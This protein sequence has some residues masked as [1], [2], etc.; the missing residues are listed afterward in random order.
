M[1]KARAHPLTR[2][3]FV[4]GAAG[5]GIAGV[6]PRV[7]ASASPREHKLVAAAARA[8]I[9]S[10]GTLTDVWAYQGTVPGPE[11][12]VRQGER[13]RVLVENR[14]PQ[15]TTVHWHGVR[16][17]NAMDGVPHLTQD[18]I[19]PGK[20]FLYEFDCPDAG[21]FWYH[22]HARSF[23]QVERG[24]SGALI[25]E[26]RTPVAADRD[27]V[28]V[29]DDW[30]LTPEA[31]I[32]EDF[33][34]MMDATHAGRLGNT[35]TINGRV[36]ER[37]AVRAGERIRLRLINAANARIFGLEFGGHQPM[38]VALD[39]QPVDPHPA[40][41]G[42]VVL[43]PA[44]RV[45]LMLDC[46]G[47]PGETFTVTDRFYARQ[48]YRLID[49]A[50]DAGPPLRESPLDA[51]VRLPANPVAVP[52]LQNATRHTIEFG[53]GMM[54]PKMARQMM[55][56]DRDRMGMMGGAME[57]MRRGSV[58]SINGVFPSAGEH[59]HVPLLTLQRDRSIIFEML[60]DTAWWHPM[61]LHGHVFRVLSRSGRAAPRGEWLDTVLMEPGER[62]EIGFVADNPGD[63][64]FHCHIL[65][66]QQAGM[67]GTVRVA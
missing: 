66:H 10:A 51:P 15:D 14:L 20:T 9:V 5:A 37:F 17:P 61:H 49:L 48:Q 39:G 27:V 52:D 16:L 33:A 44:Q 12:R 19:A 58:W 38:V 64:M 43:G 41:D 22:P 56:G 36:P 31:G 8:P 47:R 53:G 59:V 6:L 35:V 34:S 1:S 11:L 62:V 54:D 40:P 28:W 30:R 45:D 24:L 13:L 67:M 55:G 26:E 2:R 21:T 32:S 4:A 57:R 63:W 65:E 18:P 60:N 3:S 23:E 50:Y 7:G 42:R 25:V 46:S 29:L